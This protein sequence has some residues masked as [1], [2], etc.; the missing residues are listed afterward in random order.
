MLNDCLM[1]G[2]WLVAPTKDPKDFKD[3]QDL[4]NWRSLK[5]Y[6]RY[7][8]LLKNSFIRAVASSAHTPLTTSVLGWSTSGA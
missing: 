4:I 2:V 8:L 3:L 5:R 6:Q 1:F 7:L